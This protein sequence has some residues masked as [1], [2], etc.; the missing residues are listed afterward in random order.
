[1]RT[2][3]LTAALILTACDSRPP[4]QPKTID[5]INQIV[6]IADKAVSVTQRIGAG[7]STAEVQG[8]LQEMY[9]AIRAAGN[10]IS[11]MTQRIT[12]GKY[13]GRHTI[14]PIHISACTD[15][16]ISSAGWLESELMLPHLMMNAMDC[17]INARIYYED[18]S[19]D[20]GAA[21]ALAM[22]IIYPL[23]LVAH[24][25]AGLEIEPSLQEYRSVNEAIV[26]RLAPKCRER[27]GANSAGSEPVRYECAAYEVAILVRPKLETLA[28]QRP[29]T[30]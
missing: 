1:M 10:Q 22:S 4:A 16:L 26:A 15:A 24:V 9:A 30:P 18:V 14:D 21:V 27:N 28:D 2:L 20:E 23:A 12:T 13:L 17:G 8:A 3:I 7:A 11:E 19:S 25:K 29:I 6:A 5:E